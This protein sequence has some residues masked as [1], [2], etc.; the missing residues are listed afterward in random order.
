MTLQAKVGVTRDAM[1][2]RLSP[3]LLAL[4]MK[5]A[6]AKGCQ[7]PLETGQ[8]NGFFPRP[9]RKNTVLPILLLAQQGP[10]Q[11]SEQ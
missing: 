8:G 11:T 9:T 7:K 4:M 6:K 2:G 5:G 3:P 10:L 1:W